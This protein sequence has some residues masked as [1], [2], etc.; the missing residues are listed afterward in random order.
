[1]IDIVKYVIDYA[2][3]NCLHSDE[4]ECDKQESCYD[5][6]S[7]QIAKHDAAVRKQA[8]SEVEQ[9]IYELQSKYEN[10]YG[11]AITEMYVDVVYDLLEWIKEETNNEQSTARSK[12]D[13]EDAESYI[14]SARYTFKTV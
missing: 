12:T 13:R 3:S 7:A 5:C 2:H 10:Q 8:I 1:M 4:Y 9:K 14:Q 11:C 6:I